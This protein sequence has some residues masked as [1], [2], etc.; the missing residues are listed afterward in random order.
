MVV[1]ACYCKPRIGPLYSWTGRTQTMHPGAEL[2]YCFP[3]STVKWRPVR[4][5]ANNHLMPRTVILPRR[6]I[7]CRYCVLCASMLSLLLL[8]WL[9]NFSF[10]F[11]FCLCPRRVIVRIGKDRRVRM[12]APLAC[13]PH[14]FL[15]SLCTPDL[16]LL[17]ICSL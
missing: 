8:V 6:C 14:S 11:T 1:F 5:N 16:Q 9:T 3:H 15:P 4:W 10:V 13:L 12:R 17:A 7:L 2:Q